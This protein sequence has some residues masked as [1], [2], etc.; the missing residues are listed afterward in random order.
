[1]VGVGGAVGGEAA[2]AD[3]DP[4]ADASAIELV[5]AAT[6]GGMAGGEA[7]DDG[8]G[9]DGG[10]GESGGTGGVR[11]ERRGREGGCDGEAVGVGSEANRR[12][13]EA[14]AVSDC[15]RGRLTPRGGKTA[16]AVLVIASCR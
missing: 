1:M 5:T 8:D 10:G 9:G 13:L 16:A 3:A 2:P 4:L 14:V 6:G 7:T 12:R 15:V 11:D